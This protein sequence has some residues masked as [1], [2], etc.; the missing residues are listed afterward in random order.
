MFFHDNR[1]QGYHLLHNTLPLQDQDH[2]G[3]GAL[4]PVAGFSK[5]TWNTGFTLPKWGGS[6]SSTD[7]G[8]MIFWTGNGPMYFGP[9]FLLGRFNHKY[10]VERYTLSPTLGEGHGALFF[11]CLVFV[12]SC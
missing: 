7:T 6:H 2:V 8:F 3:Y 10:F 9:N 4:I 1:S 12:F 5:L 11:I